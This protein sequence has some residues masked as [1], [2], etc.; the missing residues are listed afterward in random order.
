MRG[1]P[2]QRAETGE[3]IRVHVRDD[4]ADLVEV[5]GQHDAFAVFQRGLP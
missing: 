5:R 1:Q 3:A 4:E 2:A